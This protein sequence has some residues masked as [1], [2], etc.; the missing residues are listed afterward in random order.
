[1]KIIVALKREGAREHFRLAEVDGEDDRAILMAILGKYT[2]FLYSYCP[3]MLLT[4]LPI[5]FRVL[6]KWDHSIPV[7]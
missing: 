1:M 2:G 3:Q 6:C 5:R 7:M 4:V